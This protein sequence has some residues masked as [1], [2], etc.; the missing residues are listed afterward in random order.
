LQRNASFYLYPA[1]ERKILNFPDPLISPEELNFMW[2]AKSKKP[3]DELVYLETKV[4]D[5]P[6]MASDTL[7]FLVNNSH[8]E[9]SSPLQARFLILLHEGS[10]TFFMLEANPQMEGRRSVFLHG[11]FYK[12]GFRGYIR[13]NNLPVGIFSIGLLDLKKEVF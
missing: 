3:N 8:H 12:K 7:D 9:L 4:A 6:G 13:K 10:K 5:I 2:E 11:H 1:Y